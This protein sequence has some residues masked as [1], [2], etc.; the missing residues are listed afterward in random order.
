MFDLNGRAALVAGGAGYLCLPACKELAGL[1]ASVAVADFDAENLERAVKELRELTGDTKVLSVNLD[2]S[3]E[4]SVKQAVAETV[5]AFGRLDILVVATNLSIGKTV[6]DLTAEEFQ[7]ANNTNLVGLFLLAREG[8]AAMREGGSII[9]FTSM[10][11]LVAPDPKMYD[12][13]RNPNPIEYGT[14][15]AGI[16]QMT[17]YLAGHYGPRNI[18]VNAIAPGPFP[19]PDKDAT[20]PVFVDRLASRTMLGRIG[21]RDETAGAVVFLASDASS[22]VTGQVLSV[23]GGWT[24]W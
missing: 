14:A 16:C 5:G 4:D 13:P 17:R 21:R 24:A 10:Y 20:D 12:P 15:K 3:R 6:E 2:V 22:Y 23:D 9:L 18:R 1:G 11:G 7:R 8:A 19:H